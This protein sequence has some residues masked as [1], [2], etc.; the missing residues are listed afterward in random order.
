MTKGDLRLVVRVESIIELVSILKV[1][2]SF[3][4]EA[5]QEFLPQAYIRYSEDKNY[6]RNAEIERKN[7]LRRG[8]S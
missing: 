3:K 5:R 2:V 8:M 7:S 6:R 4:T 1:G